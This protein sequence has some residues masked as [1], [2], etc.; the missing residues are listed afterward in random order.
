MQVLNALRR[1]WKRQSDDHP[2]RSMLL[3]WI[4]VLFMVDV[5]LVYLTLTS[6]R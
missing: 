1:E 3:I 5:G 4:P 6:S 2:V